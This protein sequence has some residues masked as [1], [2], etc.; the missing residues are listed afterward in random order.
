MNSFW[1][2][3]ESCLDRVI[4]GRVLSVMYKC[5][6]QRREKMNKERSCR[7]IQRKTKGMCLYVKCSIYSYDKNR[8]IEFSKK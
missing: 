1:C 5:K 7:G 4:K 6:R 3:L 8:G 2:Y